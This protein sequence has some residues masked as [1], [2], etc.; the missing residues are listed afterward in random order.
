VVPPGVLRPLFC[1]EGTILMWHRVLTAAL[2]ALVLGAVGGRLTGEEKKGH[3]GKRHDRLEALAAKLGLSDQ[4]KKQIRKIHH[5]YDQKEDKVVHRLG[6]LHHQ[7]REAVGKVLTDAQRAKAPGIM[8]EELEK[9]LREVADKLG[10][11]P[12]QRQHIQKVRAHYDERI[13][14]LHGHH[15]A[16]A[17]EHLRHLRQE[18]FHAIR[19]EL[20]EQQRARLPGILR[21]EF[22][23]WRNP[24]AG[25]KRLKAVA[26]RL[27]LSADQRQ[28]I[29]K[30]LAEHQPETERL[31]GELRHLHHEEHQAVSKVLTED[32]RAKL[33]KILEARHHGGARHTER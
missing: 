26:D 11:S 8:R 30:I 25:G 19:H 3:H 12:E 9:E 10:L 5:E 7:Q 21:E 1:G 6:E 4:Q 17:H 32:Q 22:H 23:E 31:V 2:A 15:D 29:H 13:H 27:G 18:E 33:R 28:R 14:K 24:A 20:N 16:R